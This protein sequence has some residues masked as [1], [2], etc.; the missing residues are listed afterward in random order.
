MHKVVHREPGER[1]RTQFGEG[2]PVELSQEEWDAIHG[3]DPLSVYTLR[4]KP[5]PAVHPL[6][7]DGKTGD[8]IPNPVN[9]PIF[10]LVHTV[11]ES[12][13]ECP[14]CGS[15]RQI[16]HASQNSCL[17]C[18]SHHRTH[19]D[20][21]RRLQAQANQKKGGAPKKTP[22]KPPLTLQSTGGES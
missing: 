9:D 17:G 13:E 21:K 3:D 2:P 12:D 8:M 4:G 22:G 11:Y 10:G 19:V 7:P 1:R 14:R 5:R 6:V 20:E 18:M 15:Y 16:V